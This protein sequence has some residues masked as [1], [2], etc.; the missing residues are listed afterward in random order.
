M[1]KQMV[2]NLKVT[3]TVKIKIQKIRQVIANHRIK[4]EKN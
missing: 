1:V 4:M 3:Q 2:R